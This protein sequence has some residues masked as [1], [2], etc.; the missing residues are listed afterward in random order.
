VRFKEGD[1]VMIYCALPANARGA[2]QLYSDIGIVDHIQ[3]T[4]GRVGVHW[5]S[6]TSDYW[7][8]HVERHKPKFLRLY[9]REI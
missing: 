5:L 1:I 7:K 6:D 8:G 9:C 4:R 3:S 2:Q